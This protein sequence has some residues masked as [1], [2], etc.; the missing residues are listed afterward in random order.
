MFIANDNYVVQVYPYIE[1]ISW[2]LDTIHCETL[3]NWALDHSI[4]YTAS[5]R[6][7]S[8]HSGSH[9][10]RL[11]FEGFSLLYARKQS[12]NN[13]AFTSSVSC[14]SCYIWSSRQHHDCTNLSS[15]RYLR[16]CVLWYTKYSTVC[17]CSYS[18]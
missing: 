18:Y 5:H 2:N 9:I 11:L 6:R 12:V 16:S 10:S 17:S 4:R 14:A 1:Y 15:L 3:N 8:F 13:I 7:L